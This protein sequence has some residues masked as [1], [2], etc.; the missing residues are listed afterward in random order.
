[1]S[2]SLPQLPYQYD[3]LEPYIDNKTMFVH[4]TAHHQAYVSKLNDALEVTHM[5]AIG[6]FRK[7]R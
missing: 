1:M 6:L 4:H 7:K 2:H 5:L 3:A